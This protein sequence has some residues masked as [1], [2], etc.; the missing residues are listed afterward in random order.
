MINLTIPVMGGS[1][2]VGDRVLWHSKAYGVRKGQIHKIVQELGYYGVH[3]T[4]ISVVPDSDPYGSVPLKNFPYIMKETGFVKKLISSA[5]DAMG[6]V[7]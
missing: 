2:G 3:P 6:D 4:Y 1:V 7:E 5:E